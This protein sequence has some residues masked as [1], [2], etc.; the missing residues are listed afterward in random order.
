LGK[1]NL[2][3]NR[4]LMRESVFADFINGTVHG[5]RQVL[6]AEELQLYS[7]HTGTMLLEK[8]G[9]KKALE[10]VGD[11]RMEADGSSYTVLFAEETQAGVHYA[12]PI[13]AMLDAV[14][15]YL[16]QIQ[17]IEKH[18]KEHG[19]KLQGDELLSGITRQDRLKPVVNIVF[20]LGN[21]WDGSR[22]L[23]DLLDINWNNPD[24]R[25][26]Q[27]YIP[28]FPINL[29]CAKNIQHPENFRTCLQHIF[30]MLHY[31]QDKKK[32][33]DY[34]NHHRAELNQMDSVEHMAAMVL[35]G[36]QKRVEELMEQH[37]DERE[38][39]MCKAIEDLIKDGEAVGEA[40]GEARGRALGEAQGRAL[41]EA[42]GRALGEAQLA[43]LAQAL[44]KDGRMK[45]LE[46]AISDSTYRTQLYA[47]YRLG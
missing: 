11:I 13:R 40:R 24:A 6:R 36:M 18:H 2:A 46:L 29:I 12:M 25:E 15:E 30:S 21:D 34:M 9:Q 41:G 32:L 38:I 47:E 45:D 4:L 27:K 8:D 17:D 33:Y 35:L 14:M 39:N 20:Y 26:L 28:D 31:N 10:R 42:Q 37:V 7:P 44:L 5:G 22:S 1:A 19:D 16:K 43:A 23:Y 3:V